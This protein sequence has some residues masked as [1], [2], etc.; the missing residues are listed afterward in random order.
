MLFGSATPFS[1]LVANDMPI[2]IG[3]GLRIAIGVLVLVP[4]AWGHFSSLKRLQ[5]KHWIGV[6]GIAVFGMYG[7]TV[8]ILIGLK[9]VSG[10]TGSIV[11]A[12]TPA[13]TAVAATFFL[14]E[15]WSWRKT[16]AITSAVGG[17]VLLHLM[18]DG[19]ANTL[20]RSFS[21]EDPLTNAVDSLGQKS[22]LGISL[23]FAAICCQTVFTILGKGI[24]RH[25]DPIAVVGVAAAISLPLFLPFAIIQM[26]SFQTQS[27]SVGGWAALAWYGVGSFALAAACWY[28]G[29]AGAQGV[30]AAAFMGLMPLSALLLS[31]L[32][33][34]ESFQFAHLAGFGVVLIGV[35]LMTLEHAEDPDPS[36]VR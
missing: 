4:L 26:P 27:V 18:S 31:Y 1:K 23:V 33:L 29:I 28:R 14:A 6:A 24:S 21:A 7:F 2:F 11:A 12:T 25:A 17:V 5:P 8:F 9:M 10:V 22:L 15:G 30:V 16:L 34:G 19:E 32:V 13:V 36:H 35:V 20:S 3:A